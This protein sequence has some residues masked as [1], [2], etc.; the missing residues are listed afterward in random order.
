MSNFTKEQIK[1]GQARYEAD[2]LPNNIAYF[3]IIIIVVF[4]VL[5]DNL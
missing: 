1:K 4:A 2:S 5:A 3:I